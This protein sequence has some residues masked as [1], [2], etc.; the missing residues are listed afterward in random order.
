M[1]LSIRLAKPCLSSGVGVSCG[2]GAPA[3]C[4]R[5]RH[6]GRS[7]DGRTSRDDRQQSGQ[8]HARERT[9]RLAVRLLTKGPQDLAAAPGLAHQLGHILR[10]RTVL[11]YAVGEL[12]RGHRDGGERAAEVMGCG[13][14][15]AAQRG[16]LLLTCERHLRGGQGIG[17]PARLVGDAPGA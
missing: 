17:E 2:S 10:E 12:A 15:K 14:G 4:A 11:R 3:P 16:Q 13:G 5:R 1:A 8:R 7:L 6:R 9:Q